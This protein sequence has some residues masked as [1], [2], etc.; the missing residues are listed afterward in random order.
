[1]SRRRK[2][3]KVIDR[4]DKPFLVLRWRDPETGKYRE[5]Q[6]E[7]RKRRDAERE[8]AKLEEQ[9]AAG[10][11]DD[12]E[13]LWSKFRTRYQDEHMSNL[14]DSYQSQWTAAANWLEHFHGSQLIRL[15]NLNG[16]LLSRFQESLRAHGMPVSTVAA[17]LRPIRAAVRWAEKIGLISRAPNI[18]M[19]RKLKGKVKQ[20]RSRPVTGEEF[21]RILEQV[22]IIRPADTARW[23]KFLRGLWESG[24][25]L[26][27]LLELSWDSDSPLYLDASGEIP[28]VRLWAEGHKRREDQYQPITPEFWQLVNIPE[29]DRYGYVFPLPGNAGQMTVKRVGKIISSFGE[30]AK[31]VT[32]LDKGKYATSHDMGKRAFT[33]R[34]G[35]ILSQAE[36]AEWM[37]HRSPQTTMAYYHEVKAEDLAS[38]VW[39]QKGDSADDPL[40]EQ[41]QSTSSKDKLSK[42]L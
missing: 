12:G 33:R 3:V 26:G 1:M 35:K 9:I 21:D 41:S 42:N 24:F 32:D 17:Y 38:R 22:P 37:R 6:T 10:T 13:M 19:P 28:L 5:R 2:L 11:V 15:G 8:A 39:Q 25:R 16:S 4:K 14:S 31:V 29:H 36:L 30:A 7:T 40:P 34:M 18:I 27:E 23:I 20:M